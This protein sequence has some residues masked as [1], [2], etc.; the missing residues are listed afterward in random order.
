MFIKLKLG[1]TDRMLDRLTN[2]DIPKREIENED[3]F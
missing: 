2:V 1:D 3:L